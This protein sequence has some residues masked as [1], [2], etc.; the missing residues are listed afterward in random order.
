[1]QLESV[2]SQ[3]PL[4]A[5]LNTAVHTLCLHVWPQGFDI[6]A[7][8][9]NTFKDLR[10]EYAEHGRITVY[11][12]NSCNTIYGDPAVNHMSRAWHDWA[13][14]ALGANFSVEGETAACELQCSQVIE[15]LGPEEGTRVADILRAEVIGQSLY[16]QRHRKYISLQREFV[17]A[18]LQV[19]ELA[20]AAEF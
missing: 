13:H 6:D 12:G 15:L 4:S 19:P 10:A 20:L 2:Q 16:Y 7:N 14:L 1:M 3:S 8:A 11:S 18:Y 5:T 9:P 17:E